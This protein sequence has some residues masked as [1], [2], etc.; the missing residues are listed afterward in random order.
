MNDAH[1]DALLLGPGPRSGRIGLEIQHHCVIGDAAALGQDL[2]VPGMRDS[3]LM[4]GQF[5]QR[6]RRDRVDA[7]IPREI[8]CRRQV[9]KSGATGSGVNRPRPDPGDV[10][11]IAGG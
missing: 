10:G 2:C 4:E 8:D 6:E 3:G 11:P 9:F 7:T 1:A 5:I